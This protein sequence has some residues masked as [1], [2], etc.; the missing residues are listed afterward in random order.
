MY[1]QDMGHIYHRKW[2]QVYQS[3]I[4]DWNQLTVGGQLTAVAKTPGKT[5]LKFA[6]RSGPNVEQLVDQPWKDVVKGELK[7]EALDRHLQ[8]QAT[9]ISDNG[10][11]YPVLDKVTLNLRPSACS[12]P[13]NSGGISIHNSLPQVLAKNSRDGKT[14]ISLVRTLQFTVASKI[15]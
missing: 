7:L 12:G 6:V 2:Q 8:Y 11:R 9:F 13:E 4:F 14:D 10:D 15:G 1:V 5:V 3:S